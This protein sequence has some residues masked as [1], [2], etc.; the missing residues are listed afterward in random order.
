MWFGVETLSFMAGFAPANPKEGQF[1]LEFGRVWSECLFT[2]SGRFIFKA[3]LIYRKWKTHYL[4][5]ILQG[6]AYKYL[7]DMKIQCPKHKPF[8][9][10]KLNIQGS[11]EQQMCLTPSPRSSLRARACSG[12]LGW[13][14]MGSTWEKRVCVA[15][16]GFY[17]TTRAQKKT[18]A[19]NVK[20]S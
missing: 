12:E 17:S 16:L 18:L 7:L 15:Q 3:S 4:V 20:W 10:R 1:K 6:C 13:V 9:F 2:S 19:S 14:E 11:K 5:H 8:G